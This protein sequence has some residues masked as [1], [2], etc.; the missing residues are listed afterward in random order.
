MLKADYSCLLLTPSP[1]GLVRIMAPDDRI[2][3]RD[4][5]NTLFKF[6]SP[7]TSISGYLWLQH[8]V[9]KKCDDTVLI[10]CT[11]TCFPVA[12]IL[13]KDTTIF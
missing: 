5:S 6:S 1:E 8:L 4:T 12:K 3:T 2:S 13:F 9:Q 7:K 10:A 11:H